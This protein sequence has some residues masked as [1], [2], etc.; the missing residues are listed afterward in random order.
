MA[1][2][3]RSR[4]LLLLLLLLEAA[5]ST[6]SI[7]ELREP[8]IEAADEA[9]YRTYIVQLERRAAQENMDDDARRAWH[10]SYV[11]S[12]T[13][14]LGEPRLLSSYRTVFTGFARQA[15]GGRAEASLRQ[16]RL[17]ALLPQR[18]LLPR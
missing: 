3:H 11:P 16:A 10:L 6:S 1:A 18:R 4:T 17:R 8:H 13:T 12:E 7:S 2:K 15:D 9:R 5:R 14:S